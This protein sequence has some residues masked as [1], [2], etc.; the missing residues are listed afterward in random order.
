MNP[1]PFASLLLLGVVVAQP[2]TTAPTRMTLSTT[3]QA[4]SSLAVTGFNLGNYMNVVEFRDALLEVQPGIVRFPAGNVGD[5]QDL[6]EDSLRT[7]KTNL[8]LLTQNGVTPKVIVQTRAFA[9]A[10][11]AAR[12]APEDAAEAARAAVRLGDSR[13]LLECRQRTEPV[14]GDSRRCVV[15]TGESTARCTARIGAA[16]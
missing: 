8:G 12:N 9:R 11:Q 1:V 5:D 10:G 3:P 6:T 4:I 2:V 16:I 13:G 14:R 15:D 7:L